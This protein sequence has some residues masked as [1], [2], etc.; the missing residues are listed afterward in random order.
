M[1]SCQI[2]DLLPNPYQLPTQSLKKRPYESPSL[3][4]PHQMQPNLLLVQMAMHL[5]QRQYEHLQC[6][7][8][9]TYLLDQNQVHHASRFLLLQEIDK[10]AVSVTVAMNT[11]EGSSD[12]TRTVHHRRASIHPDDIAV[13]V[14]QKGIHITA[15]LHLHPV[16]VTTAM[17]ERRGNLCPTADM[18]EMTDLAARVVSQ[19]HSLTCI[20]GLLK[21]E[22]GLT[23]RWV[24]HQPTRITQT[25]QVLLA[26][27]CQRQCH[28]KIQDLLPVDF[29]C[30]R[31]LRVSQA[32]VLT[33]VDLRLSTVMD[34]LR[35]REAVMRR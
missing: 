24:R 33:R 5:G 27:R 7:S 16:V 2:S 6:R 1:L 12:L 28:S 21:L 10:V 14:R 4:H 18:A 15:L 35:P 8:R 3:R 25:G 31:L 34:Q 23:A 9:T 22:T 13:H 19:C 26:Q 20:L 11:S 29:K 30:R 17:T 32:R